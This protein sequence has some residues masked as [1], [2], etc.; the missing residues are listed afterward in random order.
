MISELEIFLRLLM[1]AVA[2]GMV[3]FEREQHNRPA[4]FRT[5]IL[6]CVGACLMMLVSIYA[7]TGSEGDVG[8]GADPSRIA[9]SVIAGVG[10]LGAGTILRQ[11]GTI[12][13][14]TTAASLWAVSGIGIALGGGFYFGGI[15]TLLIIIISL[16]TLGNVEKFLVKKRQVKEINVRVLDRPGMLA[17]LSKILGDKGINIKD[18]VMSE[19]EFMEKYQADVINIKFFTKV[20]AK[21]KI[22]NLLNILYKTDGVLELAW[23]G[24][25]ITKDKLEK[26]F[27]SLENE[28]DI[29][30]D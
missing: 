16:Y 5:H 9:S 26:G 7:F 28:D 20:P 11:G 4:G 14:L 22:E 18:I 6:V 12:R 27:W 17:K 1:S 30:K 13:G 3:G 23:E 10:F 21:L 25:E 8:R 29:L 24:V 19:S 15:V 2:G